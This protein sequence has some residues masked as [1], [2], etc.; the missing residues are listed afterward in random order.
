VGFTDIFKWALKKKQVFFLGRIFL[1]Q[2]CL[3][4]SNIWST[5]VQMTVLCIAIILGYVVCCK[6]KRFL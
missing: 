1:Q 6:S 4:C 3:Q 5:D 2:P